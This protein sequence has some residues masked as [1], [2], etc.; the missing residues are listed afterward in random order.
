MMKKIILGFPLAVLLILLL[1]PPDGG[2]AIGVCYGRNGNNLPAA[3]EVVSLYKSKSIGG[4][5]IYNTDGATLNSLKGSNIEVIMDVAKVDIINIAKDKNAA[6]GWVKDNVINFWPA[7][8]FKYISVGNELIHRNS[9]EKYILQAISNIEAA[10]SRAGVGGKIKVSTA[11]DTGVLGQSY[12]PSNGVFSNSATYL[13]PIIQHLANTGAPL[14]VNIYPYFSYISNKAQIKL[15]YALFT[16]SGTVVTDGQY[17]YNNLF[18]ALVDSV[19]AAMEKVSPGGSRVPIVVS[20]SGW[21]SADGD[22]ASIVNAKTYNSNLIRHVNKGT[23]RRSGKPIE[24]YIFAMFNE[25]QKPA[26]YERHWGL[27]Y[28]NKNPVYSISF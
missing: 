25:N 22:S 8:K 11:V 14:L 27:F 18:D 12:P 19:Y 28:P 7:V 13:I 6:R 21:P 15:E 10:L 26:G 24:T 20:E 4:M 9:I 3:S 2:E 5:R 16:A 1:L 17:K 23:P